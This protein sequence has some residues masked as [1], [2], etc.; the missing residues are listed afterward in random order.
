MSQLARRNFEALLH[1]P[2]SWYGLDLLSTPQACAVERLICAH[3]RARARASLLHQRARITA[4]LIN[5]LY[6]PI[7]S[8]LLFILDGTND[9]SD[10]KLGTLA[11]KRRVCLALGLKRKGGDALPPETPSPPESP[12]LNGLSED[13]VS[14]PLKNDVIRLP[15]L[16]EAERP[17]R[18]HREAA[19]A[20]PAP[21]WGGEEEGEMPPLKEQCMFGHRKGE[22]VHHEA[23]RADQRD[24]NGAASSHEESPARTGEDR[25]SASESEAPC[26]A[27]CRLD[28]V[29]SV[30]PRVTRK[31]TRV[32]TIWPEALTAQL[33]SAHAQA[34]ATIESHVAALTP[35]QRQGGAGAA[36]HSVRAQPPGKL[37]W[38][39]QRS[40]AV[41]GGGLDAH[42][43]SERPVCAQSP[44][45]R[46]IPEPALQQEQDPH[47][48]AGD[49]PGGPVGCVEHPPGRDE[50]QRAGEAAAA[51][52]REAGGGAAERSGGAAADDGKQTAA[53]RQP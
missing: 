32:D 28:A 46:P 25:P 19:L 43:P 10:G 16:A 15:A 13:D 52:L 33:M 35:R 51:E 37:R 29:E 14:R 26:E 44:P 41:C 40:H 23:E 5:A 49:S 3:G 24:V 27:K 22:P 30:L 8:V 39:G 11:L 31:R 4:D 2:A 42:T 53:R 6:R 17:R 21:E 12:P 1:D 38:L 34:P 48:D 18:V 47:R 7:L 50:Q 45:E 9:I 36:C 20:L